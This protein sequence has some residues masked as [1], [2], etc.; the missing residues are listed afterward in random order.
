MNDDKYICDSC[1][2]DYAIKDFIRSQVTELQCDYCD[3]TDDEPI[4]ALVDEVY[5]FI[6]E[7]IETQYTDPNN[8]GVSWD[9]EEGNWALGEVYSAHDLLHWEIELDAPDDFL[10]ELEGYLSDQEW[11][12]IDYTLGDYSNALVAS[13]DQFCDYIKHQHQARYASLQS[14]DA[15]TQNENDPRGY[16]AA[17]MLGILDATISSLNFIRTFSKG[18]QI[19]RVRPDGHFRIAAKL[20]TAPTNIAV[21]SNRMS[22]AG[23]PMFYGA[24]DPETSLRETC[25]GKTVEATIGSFSMLRDFLLLDLTEVE[26]IPSIFDKRRRQYRSEIIFLHS[27]VTDMSR[28]ISR[29]GREHIEYAPTQVMTEY[30]RNFY[31]TKDDKKLDGIVYLSAQNSGE[32][33]CVLFVTN[34]ECGDSNAI[35]PN[36]KLALDA[37]E[38]VQLP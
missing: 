34:E 6:V 38:H 13:W 18:T 2:E 33:A 26:E 3:R 24:F 8:A 25:D 27:F 10:D 22:P 16:S 35:K 9:Y 28:P 17:D 14:E 32:R 4:A 12:E 36:H 30:F 19:F 23:N 20:G 11:C 5:D 7:G 21:Q 15:K 31:R 1:F 37:F 29:D